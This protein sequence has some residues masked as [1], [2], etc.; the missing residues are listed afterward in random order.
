MDAIDWAIEGTVNCAR[1]EEGLPDL[2]GTAL[3]SWVT[4]AATLGVTDAAALAGAGEGLCAGAALAAGF[5]AAAV[6]LA[7]AG[8]GD[9]FATG[10]AA[11]GGGAVFLAGVVT[12]FFGAG[13]LAFAGVLEMDLTGAAVFLTGAAGALVALAALILVAATGLAPVP[14]LAFL[15][16]VAFNSCL[17]IE[18]Q[19]A[20]W[21]E[22]QGAAGV[23]P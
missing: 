3:G 14:G 15:V 7:A 22:V 5:T 2:T 4:G 17:L 8:V 16:L 23:P 6:A 11:L 19:G 21:R 9:F 20:R 18:T 12:V 10:A 1:R 13:T